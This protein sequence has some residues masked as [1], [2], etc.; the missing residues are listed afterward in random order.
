MACSRCVTMARMDYD[1]EELKQLRAEIALF[2]G[3]ARDLW[4]KWLAGLAAR[5]KCKDAPSRAL[6]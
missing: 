6:H 1:E 2:P 3:W 4:L 5:L